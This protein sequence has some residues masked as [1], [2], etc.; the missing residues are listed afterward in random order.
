MVWSG[1]RIALMVAAL[2]IILSLLFSTHA[3]AAS[4][5][6]KG[7]ENKVEV[8]LVARNMDEAK[9]HGQRAGGEVTHELGLINAVAIRVPEQALEGLKHNPTCKSS[10]TAAWKYPACPAGWL[11]PLRLK[12]IAG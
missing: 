2:A 12:P 11:P 7:N 10:P 1:K 4:P 3:L 8:I 6:G 5:Q 9:E